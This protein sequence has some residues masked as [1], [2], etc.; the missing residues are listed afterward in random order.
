M[1]LCIN[2]TYSM[3]LI[4]LTLTQLTYTQWDCDIHTIIT[5]LFNIS[6]YLTLH[7][8]DENMGFPNKSLTHSP[9]N[10]NNNA[11][12]ISNPNNFTLLNPRFVAKQNQ[13]RNPS[14]ILTNTHCDKGAFFN[15][16]VLCCPSC[17]NCPC[18]SCHLDHLCHCVFVPYRFANYTLFD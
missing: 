12:I 13:Y 7:M 1:V 17:L 8:G 11:T 14:I 5:I 3:N 4:I 9:K 18:P 16:V 6:L 10:H 15:V 2:L